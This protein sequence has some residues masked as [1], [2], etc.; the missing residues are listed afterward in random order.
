MQTHRR[1]SD[2]RRIFTADFPASAELAYHDGIRVMP[3]NRIENSRK[4]GATTLPDVPGQNLHV[5]SDC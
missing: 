5:H 1:G 4:T 3:S 2:G